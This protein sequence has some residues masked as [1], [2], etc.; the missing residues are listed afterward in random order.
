MA[1]NIIF[2]ITDLDLGGSPLMVRALARGLRETGHWNPTVVSIKSAGVVA[3]WIRVEGSEVFSLHARSVRDFDAIKRYVRI[4]NHL[5]PDIIFSVLVHA[6]I[7]AAMCKR[8]GPPC[9]YVQSIHTL[10]D[11]PAWHWR[12][13]GLVN[14]AAD[15]I[16]APSRAVLEK[17]AAHG[18]FARGQVIPNGIDCHEMARAQPVP[19]EELPWEASVKVVGY[20]GR[21]DRVKNLDR[22]ILEFSQALIA[23][24]AAWQNVHLALV[25]YGKEE[26]QLKSLAKQYGIRSHVH[27]C[28][29]TFRPA[30]WM[31][32]FDVTV[33]PSLV[34]GFGLTVI[35]SMACRTPVVAYDA[36]AVNEIITDGKTGLLAAPGTPGSLMQCV[37]RVLHNA[38]LSA[39][40]SKNGEQLARQLYSQEQMIRRYDDFLRQI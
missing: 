33:M 29:R 14:G 37:Y 1:Q 25:G 17:I 23:D 31:K 38:E 27:F 34:E 22:L 3:K 26:P 15:A 11:K 8:A 6:N 12:A 30:A 13:Q 10:Q 39:D 16:I 19:S 36:P 20:I 18:H 21:F 35:E 5:E 40:L 4:I 24:Y 7:L 28:G 9:R 32:R 2:L